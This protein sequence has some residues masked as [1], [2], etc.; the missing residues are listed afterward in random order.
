MTVYSFRQYAIRC[1]TE[2]CTERSWENNTAAE[3]IAD[4][5]IDGWTRTDGQWMCPE[6]HGEELVAAEAAANARA[7]AEFLLRYHRYHPT[8]V[9]PAPTMYATQAFYRTG[10]YG[11]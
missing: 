1:D 6:P 4:A 2:G 5:E 9:E 8:A 11:E 3:A 7:D 10:P